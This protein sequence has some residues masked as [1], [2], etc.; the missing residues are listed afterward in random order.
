LVTHPRNARLPAGIRRPSTP[1]RHKFA[2]VV[3]RRDIP[4]PRPHTPE[5]GACPRRSGAFPHG[6][7]RVCTE[8]HTALSRERWRQFGG[9]TC[10]RSRDEGAGDAP[11]R[12]C[13]P[14]FPTRWTTRRCRPRR[15]LRRCPT[16]RRRRTRPR[17]VGLHRKA[18]RFDECA[19]SPGRLGSWSLRRGND[20]G[21]RHVQPFSIP[22]SPPPSSSSSS[23][24]LFFFLA[25]RCNGLSPTFATIKK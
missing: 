22:V 18:G 15:F 1:P 6:R 19:R 14:T 16:D 25:K 10:S 23:S 8:T 13:F 5:S 17:D 2:D 9:S 21:D 12:Y 7:S 3:V 24:S 4:Y 20:L 11:R